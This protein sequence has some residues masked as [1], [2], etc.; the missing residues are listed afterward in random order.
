MD[1][2]VLLVEDNETLANG[3]S[4]VL[5]LQGVQVDVIHEGRRAVGLVA[6]T[7][8]DVVVLDVTLGDIDGMTVAAALRATWPDLPIIFAT[9]D[10]ESQKM[11]AAQLDSKTTVLQKPYEIES[12]MRTIEAVTHC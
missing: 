11:R 3:V 6:H 7:H 8:P 10:V 5:R 12:L 1:T 9:G 2:R 4:L